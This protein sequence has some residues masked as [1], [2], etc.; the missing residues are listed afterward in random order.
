[1]VNHGPYLWIN[2]TFGVHPRERNL[3]IHLIFNTSPD[4]VGPVAAARPSRGAR[5]PSPSQSQRLAQTAARGPNLALNIHTNLL[6]NE[7][8]GHV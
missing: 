2:T 6:K 5:P 8:N 3:Y 4:K 7:I 1:M